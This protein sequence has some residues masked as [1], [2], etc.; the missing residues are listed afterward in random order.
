MTEQGVEITRLI[1]LTSSELSSSE[2]TPEHTL[3][4][5]HASGRFSPSMHSPPL[6]SKEKK[7]IRSKCFVINNKVGCRNDTVPK[8]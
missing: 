1:K 6:L 2:V 3:A 4:V 5:P 7:D 8:L